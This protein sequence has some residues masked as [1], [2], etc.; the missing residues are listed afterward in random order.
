MNAWK[1]GDKAYIEVQVQSAQDR[2]W[3]RPDLVEVEV[4]ELQHYVLVPRSDLLPVSA[5]DADTIE[6]ARAIIAGAIPLMP[7]YVPE[8]IVRDL[9]AAG[10]LAVREPGRSEAEIEWGV[11]YT[12]GEVTRLYTDSAIEA[13]RTSGAVL[14]RRDVRPWTLAVQVTGTEGGE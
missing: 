1:P 11:Q 2:E 13:A 3:I 8:V 5:P 14:M 4:S 7:E 12:T 6:R 10:L 9:T